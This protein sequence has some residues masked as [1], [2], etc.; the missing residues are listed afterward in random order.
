MNWKASGDPE[1]AVL[2][3][4]Y[5]VP[6]IIA[7]MRRL[8]LAVIALS[9]ALMSLVVSASGDATRSK[10]RW[11]VR[12][13]GPCGV[14]T[15][16]E[17]ACRGSLSIN[18]RGQVAG[19]SGVPEG[20]GAFLWQDGKRR[21]LPG[22]LGDGEVVA[23]NE[24]GQIVG[25]AGSGPAYHAFLWQ[26]GK[27]RDL[28]TLGGAGS[29][30]V[31]INDRG[32]V[33]GTADT[34]VD[35]KDGDFIRHAFL[36]QNGRMR[37]LGMLPGSSDSEASA[38][39]N[40]GWVIGIS[41]HDGAEAVVWPGGAITGLGKFGA[42]YSFADDI[43]E[44]GQVVGTADSDVLFLWE[45]GKSEVISD[46]LGGGFIDD[47]GRVTASGDG[48]VFR[49]EQGRLRTLGAGYASAVNE[50]GQVVGSTSLF[51]ESGVP[52]LWQSGKRIRLPLL[53]GHKAGEAVALNE[54]NQIVGF[55]GNLACCSSI[56]DP[57][58]RGRIVLWTFKR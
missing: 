20:S 37:D 15:D 54:R 7:S 24:R 28:G 8:A 38:M 10:G 56:G 13:L 30:A 14:G 12:D 26:N 47:R 58:L 55:S 35:D 25:T 16:L 46:K 34:K 42:V 19:T 4:L 40:K 45:N 23:I 36:W 32:Q 51:A 49:R 53:P 57:F 44:R 9:M 18:D 5:R 3:R 31:A 33:V 48:R 1:R 43:N 17:A 21:P 11:V 50:R 22:T 6:D 27:L 41:I 2:L 52:V 39:N 29:E